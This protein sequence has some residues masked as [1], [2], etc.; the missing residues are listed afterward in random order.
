LVG[1]MLRKLVR[2]GGGFWGER[3]EKV[4]RVNRQIFL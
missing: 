2:I 4:K 3:L 1:W